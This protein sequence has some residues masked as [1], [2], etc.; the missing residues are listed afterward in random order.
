MIRTKIN[1]EKPQNRQKNPESR[2]VPR[3]RFS[4]LQSTAALLE[5]GEVGGDIHGLVENRIAVLLLSVGGTV[6]IDLL[7]L[8]LKL[9]FL[10]VLFPAHLFIQGD[11]LFVLV[12]VVHL[13]LLAERAVFGN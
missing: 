7:R 8:V 10:L 11:A 6:Q 9:L 2:S 12:L 5:R 1:V 3:R 13:K 4:G